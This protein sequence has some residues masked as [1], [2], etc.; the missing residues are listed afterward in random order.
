[1]NIVVCKQNLYGGTDKLLERMIQWLR[2]YGYHVDVYSTEACLKNKIYDLAI[3]PSSQFGDLWEMKKS[4]IEVHHV[5]VWIMGMGAFRDSYYNPNAEKGIFRYLIRFLK[6]KASQA[7]R[8]LYSHRSIVFTDIVGV[9]NSFLAEPIDYESSL[10]ELLLP[11]A[12]EVPEEQSALERKNNSILRIMWVGRVSKDFKEIP[13]KKVIKDLEHL[14]VEG[15]SKIEFTIVGSGDAINS[16]KEYAEGYSLNIRFVEEVEYNQLGE[17]IRKNTDLLIAMGTSA[18]DGAKVSCPTVTVTPVREFDRQSVYYRWI[19][20][21]KG[22]SLGE[23]PGL[24]TATH[25]V[26]KD[27]ETIIDEYY[28]E[29]NQGKYSR[30]Y[31][32]LFEI[33][34]VFTKLVQRSLPEP[35]NAEMWKQI[36]FFYRMKKVKAL[37]KRFLKKG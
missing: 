29:D 21:S 22:Y 17:F 15:K 11:I 30:D 28:N 33:N 26:Q 3:I 8:L 24:D 36:H 37:I 7:L 2:V 9:Y 10:E 20:E 25:Q 1:M 34:H 6:Y 14:Q 23:F 31:A 19:Y 12:I 32:M 16:V 4:G 18:L 35:I 27:I 13:L 5:L